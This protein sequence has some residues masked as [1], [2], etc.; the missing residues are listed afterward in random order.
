VYEDKIYVF[1]GAP[2]QGVSAF[3]QAHVLEPQLS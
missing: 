1:S 3:S 2:Q